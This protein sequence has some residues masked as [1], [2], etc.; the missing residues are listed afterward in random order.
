[1]GQW[2]NIPPTPNWVS[3]SVVALMNVATNAHM[4]AE[5]EPYSAARRL[6][7][8]HRAAIA[9]AAAQAQQASPAANQCL[10][11]AV[12]WPPPGCPAMTNTVR[13]TQVTAAAAQVTGRIDWRIQNRRSTSMK[14]DRKS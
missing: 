7:D 2:V 6:G 5:A 4:T 3:V 1:M 11:V 10:L 8:P 12:G 13:P 14:T 9:S